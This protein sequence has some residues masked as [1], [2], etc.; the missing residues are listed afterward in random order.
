MATADNSESVARVILRA[1]QRNQRVFVTYT[2]ERETEAV[3]FAQQLGAEIVSP[4]S[5][6]RDTPKTVLKDAA[7]RANLDGL[8]YVGDPDERINFHASAEQARKGFVTD[9][10]YEQRGNDAKPTKSKAVGVMVGIPAYNEESTIDNVVRS[11][12]EYADIVMVVDDGS[13]DQTREQA[14]EAGAIVVQ[15]ERNRGYG[16]ALQT[17][18]IEAAGQSAEHLV[19]L[20]GDGQHHSEDI[21]RL[22]EKQEKSGAEI[23]IGSRFMN[24]GATDAPLYRRYGL[25]VVNTLTNLSISNGHSGSVTDTQSGFRAYDS[26]AIASL[27]ESD[28]VGDHMSASVDILHHAHNNDFEI[29]EIG[30]TITYD[31]ENANEHHPLSHGAQLLQ[32]ILLTIEKDRPISILGIPGFLMAL[33][34]TGFGYWTVTNYIQTGTFP[35]GLALSSAIFGLAGIFA[36]FTAIILHS[37]DQHLED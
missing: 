32:N 20:D 14:E 18:F 28:D 22:V 21:P 24:S 8:L 37:L 9:P 6:A 15:H 10:I 27:A 36:T 19:V 4:P 1:Q 34:G 12:R 13:K 7:K 25:S 35:L 30:T 11:V 33:V 5:A 3:L 29:R 23:V 31:V 2:D 16:A 17:L 26:R